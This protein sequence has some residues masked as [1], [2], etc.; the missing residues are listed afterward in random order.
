[1]TISFT[2]IPGNIK[3]P[4]FYA[5]F[6]NSNA[7]TVGAGSLEVLMIG[8]KLSTGSVAALTPTTVTSA[9]NAATFFGA[10]SMLARMAAKYL[11]N[12]SFN[13]LVCV[14]LED[15]VAGVAATG[16]VEF[17]GTATAAGVAVV[18]VGGR[19]YQVAVANTDTAAAIAT[20]VAAAINADQERV[21]D[22][23]PTAGVV[24]LTARNDGE[25]GNS[26]AIEVQYFDG[27]ELP[28]G[29]TATVTAMAS[30]AG[31][32]DVSTVFPVIGE[33]QYIFVVSPYKDATNLA[34]VEA[35]LLDR[36]GPLRQ[37]D[38]Y[39]IYAMKNTLGNLSAFGD[40]KN[41][42]LTTIMGY[43]GGLE[44]E[45][46]W[47]SAVTGAIVGPIQID[48]ARPMQTLQVKGISAPRK[49]DRFTIA[50]QQILID[51]GI[52][53]YFVSANGDVLI[54]R[55]VT[56]FKKNKFGSPD[57]SYMDLNSPL[58]LSLLRQEVKS[59]TESK[60]PRHKLGNDG[61][62]FGAGQA[63]VTPNVYKAELVGLAIDWVR[64]GLIENIDA[65]K[66]GLIVERN[67]QDPNRLDVCMPPDL[68]N[69]LRIVGM[70]IQ[71]L[72]QGEA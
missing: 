56:T 71:F 47:A 51:S 67:A 14:A 33:D 6:D 55:M 21:A 60:Y 22:A 65:F 30:G 39:G 17:T 13:K 32:P 19:K 16:Q 58:T 2:D 35:E 26:I 46:E 37:N 59:M 53:T 45:A 20:A 36:F 57:N 1:M 5:E 23:A 7:S 9:E 34:A 69:Q 54:Q 28:S 64:R 48:P 61:E 18:Y 44:D 12:N 72:L 50:E 27:E 8:Q 42:Q 68:V 52:A 31:N 66:E 38:G 41:T 29:I 70:K 63:I 24:A 49:V 3:V 62:N 15:L 10:G 11:A 40:T 25:I 43:Q 4:L